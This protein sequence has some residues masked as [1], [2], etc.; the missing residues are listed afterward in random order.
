MILKC[1]ADTVSYLINMDTL[2]DIAFTRLQT[3]MPH[4]T[5][6][7]KREIISYL[8]KIETLLLKLTRRFRE[9]QEFLERT[10]E[11]RADNT[12]F[13]PQSALRL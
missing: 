4:M 8:M 1:L 3:S 9:F 12:L 2:E 7:Y 5:H 13:I 11:P 6:A 10:S